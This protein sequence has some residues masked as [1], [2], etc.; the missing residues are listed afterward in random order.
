VMSEIEQRRGEG[1]RWP[2][3]VALWRRQLWCCHGEPQGRW[4]PGVQREL[5]LVEV[6]GGQPTA[7]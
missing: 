7:F 4:S 1:G 3:Q 5:V 2:I 6:G